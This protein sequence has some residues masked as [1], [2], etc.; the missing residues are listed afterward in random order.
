ME[1]FKL[2][3]EEA[4]K[5]GIKVIID[6]VINHVSNTH[7]WFQDALKGPESPYYDWFIWSDTVIHEEGPW[8]QPVWN[9]PDGGQSYYLRFSIF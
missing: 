1:E 3:I 7:P 6:L 2:L 9:T 8:G 4:H 5:R